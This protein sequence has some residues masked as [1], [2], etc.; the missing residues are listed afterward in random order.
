MQVICPKDLNVDNIN[1]A[2]ELSVGTTAFVVNQSGSIGIGTSSPDTPL[3]IKV[4]SMKIEGAGSASIDLYDGSTELG[5]V[6]HIG[7]QNLILNNKKS[8]NL[9]LWTNDSQQGL[10]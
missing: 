6:G 2:E 7:D 3:H 5:Q 9:E 1:I 8:G 4:D 10:F